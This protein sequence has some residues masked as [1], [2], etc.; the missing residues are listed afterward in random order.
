MFVRNGKAHVYVVDYTMVSL[1]YVARKSCFE[2]PVTMF[3]VPCEHM[4]N[5]I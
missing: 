4:H 3:V 5:V 2:I 1:V